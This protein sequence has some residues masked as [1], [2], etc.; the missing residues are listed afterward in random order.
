MAGRLMQGYLRQDGRKGIRNHAVV[1]FLVECARHVGEEISDAVADTGVQLIGFPSCYPSAYGDKMLNALATHPNVGAALLISLGCESF[2]G[3]T[4]EAAIAAS[5]R[6]G[7]LLIIQQAG[8]TRATIAAGKAW[9]DA[10]FEGFNAQPM[11]ETGLAD[12][13]VGILPG[14]A[15]LESSQLIGQ[16]TDQLLQAGAAVI[17]DDPAKGRNLGAKAINQEIASQLAGL[18]E[19]AAHCRTQFSEQEYGA[20]SFAQITGSARV[21]GLLRPG[22][23][24]QRD[25]LYLLDNVPQGEP[26]YGPIDLG[27]A[28]AAAELSACGAQLLV[29]AADD[30]ELAGSALAPLVMVAADPGRASAADIDATDLDGAMAAIRDALNG[31]K[32][33][34]ERLG[35]CD[36]A[37]VHKSLQADRVNP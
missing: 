7:K 9:L 12:L 6:P 34:A 23:A 4:L 35:Y 22:Q 29:G 13:V 28:V 21:A 1:A 18:A 30:G 16:V 10:M 19:R 26:H 11:A 33:A 5:G 17:L 24:P 14:R 25:G 15:S 36:F 37:L 32:T 20:R 2:R 27:P 8:G 31:R 3:A